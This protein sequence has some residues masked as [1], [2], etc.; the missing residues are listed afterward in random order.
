MAF[1]NERKQL[2]MATVADD[3]G[4]YY[5]GGRI[6]GKWG[7]QSKEAEKKFL[8]DWGVLTEEK[9]PPD[10]LWDGIKYFAQEECRCRCG[11][12][13][14]DGKKE[15]VRELLEVADEIR[16]E[17]GGPLIPTSVIRCE[18]WNEQQGGVAG[19]RHK[20]GKAMD[21]WNPGMTSEELLAAANAN[22]RVRYAYAVDE[23]VIHFDVE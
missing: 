3:T 20:L 10:S 17:I 18:E 11:G 22:P 6:D 4:Q 5:Y 14:C 13:Y 1:S 7:P 9:K 15:P 21:A 23:R 12:K 8:T 19:S 16:E 2:I